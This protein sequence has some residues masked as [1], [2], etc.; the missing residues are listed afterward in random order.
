MTMRYFKSINN[1][2]VLGIGIGNVCTEITEAEYS[3]LLEVIRNKPM[4]E[5][6]YDYRLKTDLTWERCETH[7]NEE[8]DEEITLEDAVSE[9]DRLKALLEQNGI[10]YEKGE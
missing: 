2:Y 6:G 1:G 3:T 9:V 5:N 8:L 10:S 7:T 4:S